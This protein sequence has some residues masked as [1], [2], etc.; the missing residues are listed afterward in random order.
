MRY[1]ERHKN[2]RRENCSVIRIPVANALQMPESTL[3]V[4]PYVYGL[5]LGNGNT[6]KPEITICTRDVESFLKQVPYEITNAL[7]AE[8]RRELDFPHSRAQAHPAVQFPAEAY[9]G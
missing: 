3:P 2:D 1:R 4:D 9:P 8:R 6:V 5:W 7:G